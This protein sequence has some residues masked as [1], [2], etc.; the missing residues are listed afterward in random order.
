MII[1]FIPNAATLAVYLIEE[2][3]LA[4]MA[5]SH[6]KTPFLFSATLY[7]VSYERRFSSNEIKRFLKLLWK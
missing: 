7:W 4:Q 5:H 1:I 3:K 2:K 6:F